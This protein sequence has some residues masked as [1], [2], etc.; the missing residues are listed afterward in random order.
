ME[1]NRRDFLKGAGALGALGA[2]G[3]LASCAPA[4][5]KTA[6]DG[7]GESATADGALT[8]QSAT[9]KWS[10]EIPPEPIADEDIAET[11]SADVIVVGAGM[12]GTCCAVSAAEGGLSVI[13][14][15]AGTKAISR[16]GSNQAI[17]TKYQKEMG[18]DYTPK[19][20]LEHVKIEQLAGFYS[21]DKMKWS[22]WLQYSG[23]SM[24]WMIDKMTAKGLKVNLEPPY[25]DP[26]GT[27]AAPASVHNFWN[28][29]N[30]LGVFQ[31]APLCAQ[32]YADTLTQDLG[33]E[34]HFQT[35]GVQL[36]RENDN[37]GRV[38]AVIAKRAD[39][40]YAKYEAAKAVVLATGDFSKDEDMMAKYAPDIYHA[41]KDQLTFGEDAVDFDAGMNYSGLMPGDG[42]KMGLWVGAAW[43][44]VFPNPCAVNGGVPGPS[45]CVIDNFWGINLN[46]N[47]KRF[48]NENTNFAFGARSLLTQPQTTAFGIWD[49]AYAYTQDEWETLGCSV[50]NVTP[51]KPLTPEQMIASWDANVEKGTYFKA[52]T[53]EELLDQLEGIDKEEALASIERYNT[54]A[55]QGYDEEY[56]VNP[57]ILFPISTPP[58]YGAKTTGVTFLTVMG[59]LRTNENLQI[60]EED[61]TPIEGLY[62]VGTMIGDF[63]AGTYNFGLPGQNL[64]A[65]CCTLP[66]VLGRDLAKL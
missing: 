50:N 23:E 62:C 26:D 7:A 60:C 27:L 9:Q 42:H 28:D 20:A 21:M 47:G 4:S 38:S 54:Y 30:P 63:F 15:D 55:E 17:G 12:A 2:M 1:L 61:D 32:A 43:Q 53:L 29:E 52:D 34:I 16:G 58:F 10:F 24:D 65:C 3:T 13:L 49:S 40:T 59:G 35:R 41:L 18:I 66:Y 8:A 11:F 56:Q 51:Q 25:T 6:A 64:G 22:R 44:R 14:I 57:S 19:D 33:Q 45:H 48:Q 46:I 37:T 36:V 39:G 5:P 31:G